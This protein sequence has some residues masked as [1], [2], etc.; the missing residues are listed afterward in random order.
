MNG[1]H[2]H[3]LATDCSVTLSAKQFC[4]GEPGTM[5]LSRIPMA[6]SHGNTADQVAWGLVSGKCF[7]NLLRDTSPLAVFDLNKRHDGQSDCSAKPAA[8]AGSRRTRSFRRSYYFLT[9]EHL[10]SL[11]GWATSSAGMRR[12]ENCSHD[13]GGDYSVKSPNGHSSVR[14]TMV[15]ESARLVLSGLSCTSSNV[16][17]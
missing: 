16:Q 10:L 14:R 4:H 3:A 7:S 9:S 17:H 8:L 11:S 6:R 12:L 2:G 1:R 13:L 15:V 5:C